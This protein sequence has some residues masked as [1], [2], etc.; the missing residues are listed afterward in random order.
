MEMQI[1]TLTVILIGAWQVGLTRHREVLAI[2]NLT[3]ERMTVA[4]T[5]AWETQRQT[6]HLRARRGQRQTRHLRARHGQQIQRQ[7]R[8]LR[9]PW[10][11]QELK[12]GTS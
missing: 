1:A 9:E 12:E 10:R 6:R 5:L 7:T 3:M 4:E 8:H 2:E 11:H